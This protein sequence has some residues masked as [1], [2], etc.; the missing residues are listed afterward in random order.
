MKRCFK[1]LLVKPLD[2]FYPHPRMGDGHLNK[3]KKCTIMDV[4]SRYR[5]KRELVA[6]YEREREKSPHRKV[7]KLEYQRNSRE[8]DPEKSRT[9]VRTSKAIRRGD[10][11][12]LPCEK[13][14]DPKSEAHHLDYSD[15]LKIQWLCFRHHREL[16]GQTVML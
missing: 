10:L 9:R 13:C 15:H 1:C 14:G 12:R 8:K 2:S 7:K 4:K 5:D 16:H 11:T 6:E 3:C